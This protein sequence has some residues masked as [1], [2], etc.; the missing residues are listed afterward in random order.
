[1]S[2]ISV[3]PVDASSPDFFS[4]PDCSCFCLP[5]KLL[6]PSTQCW[7]LQFPVLLVF[8]TSYSLFLLSCPALNHILLVL[9]H[10]VLPTNYRAI[11]SV[12]WARNSLLFI[13]VTFVYL[14]DLSSLITRCFPQ[15]WSKLSTADS[16]TPHGV[17]YHPHQSCNFT[18]ICDSF[19][20]ARLPPRS[21]LLSLFS[22]CS[23]LT[24]HCPLLY[25]RA[26]LVSTDQ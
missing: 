10:S 20:H 26:A 23:Y 15:T 13:L 3:T 5:F 22:R 19:I 16:Q 6:F 18:F 9:N 24:L 12:S 25:F 4:L 7:I 17:R 11:A 14:S 1:M 2:A 21:L 8:Q